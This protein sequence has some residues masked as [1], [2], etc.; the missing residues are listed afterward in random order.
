MQTEASDR[1]IGVVLLQEEGEHK[2]LLAYASRKLK[3]SEVHYSTIESAWVS[4]GQYKI[5]KT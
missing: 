1:G 4:Y 2:L 5:C 3:L